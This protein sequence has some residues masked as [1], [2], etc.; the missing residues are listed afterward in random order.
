MRNTFTITI[1]I[2]ADCSYYEL[3]TVDNAKS[4]AIVFQSF[5][6]LM[7]LV[8][9]TSIMLLVCLA[10]TNVS[11]KDWFKN[12]WR[13]VL[14]LFIAISAIVLLVTLLLMFSFFKVL[15]VLLY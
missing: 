12:I 5:Y 15:F 3:S 14:T 6:G 7:Q 1:N 8:G 13:L 11:Y 2:K 4:F 10:Y 9:P